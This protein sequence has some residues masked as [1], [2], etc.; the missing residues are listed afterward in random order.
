MGRLSN[1]LYDRFLVLVVMLGLSGS[2]WADQPRIIDVRRSIPLSDAEP[3][4]KDFYI[5]VEPGTSLKK[6]STVTA[7]RKISIREANALNPLGEITVP[8][9]QLK[10]IFIE[11]NIAVAREVKLLSRDGLPMLDQTAI[12]AGDL[13]Q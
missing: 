10:V 11:N 4:Y 6:D 7:V 2:G 9:G 3:V 13:V 5:K 12:M 8:V 1:F